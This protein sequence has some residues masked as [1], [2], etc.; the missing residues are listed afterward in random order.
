M[1]QSD[2]TR[3]DQLFH[4]AFDANGS[5]KSNCSDEL[6][7]RLIEVCQRVNPTGRYGNSASRRISINA[8]LIASLHKEYFS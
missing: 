2:L 7:R 5:L 4:I 3:F 1:N 6:K 8:N